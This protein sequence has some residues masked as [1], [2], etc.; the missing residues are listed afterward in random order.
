MLMHLGVHDKNQY[1]L[2]KLRDRSYTSERNQPR[3]AKTEME[4]KT[5]PEPKKVRFNLKPKIHVIVYWS[6]AYREARKGPWQEIAR[7]NERFRRRIALADRV[8]RPIFEATH[9][10]RIERRNKELTCPDEGE[11][12]HVKP[13]KIAVSSRRHSILQ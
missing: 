12:K 1:L 13:L 7:N 11:V 2:R 3:T 4:D 5:D 10:N 9:R 8:L 6:Y